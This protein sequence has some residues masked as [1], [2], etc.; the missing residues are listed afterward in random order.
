[1]KTYDE[2]MDNIQKKAKKIKTRRRVIASSL[3]AVFVLVLCV[4]LF[5]P[6][7]GLTPNVNKYQNSPYY[8]LIHWL[9]KHNSNQPQYKNNYEKLIAKLKKLSYNYDYGASGDMIV[10]AP[11]ASDDSLMDGASGAP[12]DSGVNGGESYVEVTDNQVAGVVEGD[13]FKRSDRYLYHLQDE[14]LNVYSI[15]GEDSALVGSFRLYDDLEK[16]FSECSYSATEMYLSEDCTRVTVVLNVWTKKTSNMVGIVSLDVSDPTNIRV[17]EQNY[18]PGNGGS[19]RMIDGKLLLTYYYWIRSGIDYDDPQTFVPSYG[20]PEH[21]ELVAADDIVCPEDPTR[22]AYTVVALLDANTAQVLD[23]HAIFDYAYDIYVSRST[24]YLAAETTRYNTNGYY[25]GVEITGIGYDADGLQT[26]GAIILD[27]WV[28]NQYYLDE[29]DGYLRVFTSTRG[30]EG[31][32]LKENCNFYCVDLSDWTVAAEVV[33]FAP[34]GD[35]VTSVRFDGTSAYV[36]TADVAKLTD[37]V[38]FFDLS[39]ITNITWKNTPIIDGFSSS[40]IRFGD[41]LVGIGMNEDRCLKVEAYAQGTDDVISIAAYEIEADFSAE[42]KSYFIDRNAGYLGI[43]ILRYDYTN[44]YDGYTNEYLLLHFDGENFAVVTSVA[45]Q[46][47]RENARATIID[48]Y[49]YVLGT[50]LQVVKL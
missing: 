22:S 40:L 15:A 6:Y 11:G 8:Q 32:Q 2:Y 33:G 26:M 35:E 49:L 38:Y 31:R 45:F 4:T 42:Y 23:T 48:G 29:Y 43:P 16:T 24:V 5:Y 39:D 27:G 25:R 3:T 28:D 18:F 10:E 9:N 36:C 13:I 44:L 34:D 50:T 1:M 41:A 12:G 19:T 46:G 30:R 20:T 7:D 17:A 14:A 47:G 37:P 21:M